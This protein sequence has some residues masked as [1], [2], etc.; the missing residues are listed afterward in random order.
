MIFR[1]L[2]IS[3]MHSISIDWWVG[4]TLGESSFLEVVLIECAN[5]Y[6]F[7][8][9]V[10]ENCTFCK[11][12]SPRFKCCSLTFLHVQFGAFSVNLEDSLCVCI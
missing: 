3:V 9:T 12:R 6:Q 11:L 2:A 5:L 10:L 1:V 4:C 8:V 7:I